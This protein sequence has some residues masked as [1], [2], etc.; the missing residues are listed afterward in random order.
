MSQIDK[1]REEGN[2]ALGY[3]L[4][5]RPDLVEPLIPQ[6]SVDGDIDPLWCADF[7]ALELLKK[8]YSK[9]ST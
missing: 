6:H 8:A 1:A 4:F 9:E 3:W 5:N 2:L 7:V